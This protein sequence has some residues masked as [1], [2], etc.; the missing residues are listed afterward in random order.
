MADWLLI[1]LP[2][3]PEQPATWLTVDPRGN[4]SGPPQSGPLS[5]AAPRAVGRRICVL[6]PGTDVLLTEPEVPMKAGTKLHQVVPFALE[7]QLA[8]DI[9]DLHFAIGKRAADSAK[10]PVAVIRRSLMDEW[11]TALRSN[12]LDPESM[13]T[14]SDLLPQNPGQ[15]IALMEE[16]VVVVRPPSG[17]PVTLPVEALGEA[18]EIAQ[19]GTGDQAATGGRGLI[20]YTG[21]AEWHQHS[22][23]IEAL[24]ERFDGIKIQ[25]LSAGPLALF[26]QQLPTATPINLLQG[27]YAPTKASTVGWQSWKVAAILLVCLIGLHVAGKA[28]EL[29]ALKHSEHTLDASIGDT[30]RQAMPGETNSTNARQRMEQRLAA[31]QNAGGPDGLLPALQALVDARAAAPGAKLKALSYRQGTV[32]MKVA[33]KDATSL[34]HLT[35]SLKSR[36]RQAELTSGNTTGTGYEGRI[37]LRGK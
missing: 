36:G 19:Q 28:A 10:T 3:T 26:G 9:D 13:Y 22:A 34:D 17:S 25:L 31:A 2:R 15:A 12:G 29:T 24:R 33:A 1:R 14:E 7:E 18:L 21:A 6:V 11:L 16:D 32:D 23:K 30:F 20:L 37:V 27:S 8:D 35:Q 4:P 5:L